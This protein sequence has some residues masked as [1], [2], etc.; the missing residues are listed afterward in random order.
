[1][2]RKRMR[3]SKRWVGVGAEAG[4][5]R[6]PPLCCASTLGGPM[7]ILYYSPGTASMVVHLLLLELGAPH[8][9]RRVDLDAGGQRDP[10]YLKLNPGGVVPTLIV[11]GEA[12]C[13]AAA[14]ALLLAERHPEARLSPVPGSPQRGA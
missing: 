2:G 10:A 6:A 3:P 14:L 5:P 4:S 1:M 8:E 12:R 7:Y 11:D 13:E 9:L